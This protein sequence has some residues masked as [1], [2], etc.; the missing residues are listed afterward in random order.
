MDQVELAALCFSFG[1][2]LC[3]EGYKLTSVL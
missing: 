2:I 3:Y 1:H